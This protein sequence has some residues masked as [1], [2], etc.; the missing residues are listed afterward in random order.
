[1]TL[2][3]LT[4]SQFT[5]CYE[6][7]EVP[8]LRALLAMKLEE[9][10]EKS[11]IIYLELIPEYADRKDVMLTVINRLENIFIKVPGWKHL[12]VSA[13]LKAFQ[14]IC[15]IKDDYGEE[16]DWLLPYLAD[17]HILMSYFAGV[18]GR[19]WHTGVETALTEIYKKNTL[20]S[21]KKVTKISPGHRMLFSCWVKLC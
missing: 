15:S 17:I 8:N 6:K 4:Q 13:D 7:Q 9:I 21:I 11:Q 20:E 3:V 14:M 1:M 2:H 18:L 12:V 5:K 16:M 10:V 19:H